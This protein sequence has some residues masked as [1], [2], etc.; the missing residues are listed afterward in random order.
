MPADPIEAALAAASEAE[1]HESLWAALEPHR[2]AL[3]SDARLAAMWAEALRTSPRRPSL[4]DEAEVV[5]EAWPHEASLVLRACD[6]LL[7]AAERPIDEPPLEADEASLAA[8]ATAR[9]LAKLDPADAADAEIGGRLLAQRAH[10]LRLLGPKRLDDALSTMR[11][12]IA[13]APDAPAWQADLAILHKHRREL[14]EMFVASQK[15]VDGGA[16]KGAVWNLAIA[17]TALGKSAE[18]QAAW[19]RLG[20]EAAVREGALPLVEGLEPAQVRLPTRTP[21]LGPEDIPEVAAGFE[22][23]WVQPLSPCHGVVRSPTQRDAVADFGDVVLWD[24]APVWVRPV[25]GRPTPCFPLLAVLRRGDERR[26]RFLAMQQQQGQVDALSEA[27][28]EDVR[29]YAH[30]ERIERMCPRCAAGDSMLRHEHLPEEEHRLVFGKLLAP[31][32]LG[33]EALARALDEA[34]KAHPGVLLAV[35]GLFEAIGDSAQAGKHHQRWGAISRSLGPGQ[36]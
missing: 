15:A 4:K 21:D 25:D 1:D 30:G 22:V 27:L 18:A 19:A 3:G 32:E 35:P 16:G 36:S 26:F 23:V 2:E 6:A 20:I 34:K 5:L 31:G 9:C 29:L 14:P 24:G 8:G 11:R 13:T 10:A 33:L 7:R 12:A 17:A 28:P